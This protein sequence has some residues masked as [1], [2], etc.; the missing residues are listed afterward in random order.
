MRTNRIALA[1]SVLLLTTWSRCDRESA[2]TLAREASGALAARGLTV[3]AFAEVSHYP[4]AAQG[5]ERVECSAVSR[6][7]ADCRVCLVAYEDADAALAAVNSKIK[8]ALPEGSAYFVR[9]KTILVVEPGPRRPN[10]L[11]QEVHDALTALP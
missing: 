7:D 4:A 10:S 8:A 11:I 3:G 1:V 6:Q 2:A 5:R 9:G